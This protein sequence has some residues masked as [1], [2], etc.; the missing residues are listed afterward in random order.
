M[1]ALQVQDIIVLEHAISRQNATNK[2]TTPHIKQFLCLASAKRSAK[3]DN[4]GG[5]RL[6]PYSGNS[7][8][9]DVVNGECYTALTVS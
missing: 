3:G 4:S 7:A 2:Q 1:I 8:L 6:G 9:K 5:N